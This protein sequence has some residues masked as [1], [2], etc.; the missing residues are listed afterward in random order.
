MWPGLENQSRKALVRLDLK[1]VLEGP[2]ELFAGR[3]TNGPAT[4]Q[5]GQEGWS[6]VV[7]G[8]EPSVV[9]KYIVVELRHVGGRFFHN[10]A[11]SAGSWESAIKSISGWSLLYLL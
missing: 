3:Y 6:A 11:C 9:S 7:A 10:P 5:L 4:K 8:I 2:A 1:V